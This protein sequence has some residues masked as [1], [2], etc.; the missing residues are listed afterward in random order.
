VENPFSYYL[1]GLLQK[2]PIKLVKKKIKQQD[3]HGCEILTKLRRSK[4]KI[5]LL[6]PL[7]HLFF[8]FFIFS[9]KSEKNY[10]SIIWFL[11][12]VWWYL[13]ILFYLT[14]FIIFLLCFLV[15]FKIKIHNCWNVRSYDPL[16]TYN[17]I[18]DYIIETV[19]FFVQII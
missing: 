7:F 17:H 18:S 8:K 2:L 6:R 13:F 4:S 14:Y 19:L 9:R 10:F 5:Q 16:L 12:S 11:K 15:D 3:S 1:I